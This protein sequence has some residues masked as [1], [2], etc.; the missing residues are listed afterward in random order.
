M[1]DLYALFKLHKIDRALYGLQQ[2]A[3]ALDV[4][5]A[6]AKMLKALATEYE[7]IGGKASALTK[8]IKD[9]EFEQKSIEQK[10]E[11]IQKKLYDGSIVSPKEI[12][13]YEKEVEMLKE[14]GEKN[15]GRLLELY[16]LAPPVVEQA[17]KIKDRIDAVQAQKDERRRQAQERH[18]AIKAEFESLRASRPDAARAIDRDLYER[19]EEV[20]K[21]TGSTAMAEVTEQGTCENCGMSV[22]PKQVQLLNEDR[23]T[24]C[25][26]CHRILF[27]VLQEANP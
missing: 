26:G 6:E 22:P 7:D 12:E 19:Y 8:E 1:S 10:I 21:H 20:R 11:G 2:E 14:M 23:L 16:E 25:E 24:F 18:T 17:K 5:R 15:D 4:G 27:K 13:N 9:R 3:A